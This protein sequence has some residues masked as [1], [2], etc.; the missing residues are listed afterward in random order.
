MDVCLP[1]RADLRVSVGER[2][3]GGVTVLA[4]L[5]SAGAR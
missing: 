5:R 1:T 3:I 4:T 2:V